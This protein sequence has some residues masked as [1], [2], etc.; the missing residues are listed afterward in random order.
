MA[1]T[2]D[3]TTRAL[4]CGYG[5]NVVI[6]STDLDIPGGQITCILGPSG[7]GKSTLM[8]T[9]LLLVPRISGEIRFG[10][11]RVDQLNK[12]QMREFRPRIGVLFQGSALFT[13]MTLEENV[14]FPVIERTHL[15][16]PRALELARHKLDLV[17]LA[18]FA[19]RMPD[20]ISGGMR[21]RCGIARALALDPQWLFLDEPSAGLDPLTAVELDRLILDLRE[22]LGTT[23]VMVT[24]E[25]PSVELVS[26]HIIMLHSD[27]VQATGPLAQVRESEDPLIRNFFLRRA[28]GTEP[29]TTTEGLAS[30]LEPPLRP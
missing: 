17:G 9:L 19:D 25:V 12:Q 8:R 23:I 18:P 15:P 7:C 24:H 5:R 20:A 22:V 21:K 2:G 16:A 6:E 29:L 14:A 10:Q 1:H 13:S 11:H 3:I 27:R 4:V 26:D 30:K 28:R